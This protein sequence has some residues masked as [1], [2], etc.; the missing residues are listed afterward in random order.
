M[1]D[2]LFT[3]HDVY[4][5]EGKQISKDYNELIKNFLKGKEHYNTIQLKY[6]LEQQ[7]DIECSKIRTDKHLILIKRQWNE[8]QNKI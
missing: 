5:D 1:N 8:K 6:I 7:L 4:N 3:T 2:P